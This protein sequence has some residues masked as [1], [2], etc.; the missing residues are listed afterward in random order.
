M[1]YDVN[2]TP[3][4]TPKPDST[5]TTKTAPQTNVNSPVALYLGGAAVVAATLAGVN[6]VSKKSKKKSE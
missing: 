1:A 4:H 2:V 5:K 6:V 3:K